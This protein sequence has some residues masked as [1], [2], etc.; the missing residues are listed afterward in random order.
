MASSFWEKIRVIERSFSLSSLLTRPLNTLTIPFGLV[1]WRRAWGFDKPVLSEVEGLS[2]NGT[3]G[4]Y[5]GRVNKAH[6]AHSAEIHN[7][8]HDYPRPDSDQQDIVRH[9]HIAVSRRRHTDLHDDCRW[10][11]VEHHVG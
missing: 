2:P 8:I 3:T 4:I 9:A 10:Q 11:F 1:E 5:K 7:R 6:S